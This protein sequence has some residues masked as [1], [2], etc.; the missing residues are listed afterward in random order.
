MPRPP[1]LADY[2]N[3][4]L[5][6]VAI[7]VQFDALPNYRQIWAGPLWEM[8][9][10]RFPVT[11][12]QLPLQPVFETFGAL[13]P[14]IAFRLV[15]PLLSRMW[16]LNE[17]RTELLQFQSDR[18][19]RNWQKLPPL[20]NSYPRFENIIAE[21]S[22]DFLNLAEFCADKKI[23]Q[24][25]PSQC[26]LTYVNFVS[27]AD[28]QAAGTDGPFRF[29]HF[30][31]DFKPDSM[32]A[33]FTQNLSDAKG[34]QFGRVH[35]QATSAHRF[36]GVQGIN[37]TITARGAPVERSV[38]SSISR[39]SEFRTKIVQTFDSITSEVAHRAWGRK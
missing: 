15:D 21:F 26:E 14:S 2:T 28:V 35:V 18:F 16:F 6:E 29:Q 19:G 11:Q 36:D 3:P 20:N 38:P 8:F 5:I 9:R 1:D 24:I 30:G 23:G 39:L 22:V 17:N 25:A 33:L 32:N 37:M 27:L 31:D 4:P 13:S 12:D 7:S 34:E 10:E